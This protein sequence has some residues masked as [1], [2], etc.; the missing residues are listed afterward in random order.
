LVDKEAILGVL[1]KVIIQH[2]VEEIKINSVGVK[3]MELNWNEGTEL[4]R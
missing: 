2:F 1:M 3:N 4:T